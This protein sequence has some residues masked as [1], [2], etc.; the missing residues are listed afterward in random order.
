MFRIVLPLLALLTSISLISPAAAQ[1]IKLATLA[2]KGSPWHEVM[3]DLGEEW[4]EASG[5]KVTLRIYPGGVI[6]DEPDMVRK[7]RIGQLH[8]AALTGAGLSGIAPEIQALQMPM[9]F[10]SDRELSCTRGTIGPKLEAI[11]E[12]KGFKVLAWGNAGWVYFFAPGPVIEPKDM[13][14][15]S[16]FVWTG[17]TAVVEAYK[18][19]GFKPVPLAATEILAALQSGLVQSFPTTPVAALSFQWFGLAKH[20]ADIKWAPLIGA[21]V[22]STKKWQS[23][24]D[25]L[26]P[27]L[28]EMARAAGERLRREMPKLEAQAIEAMKSHGL[29]VHPVPSDKIASWEQVAQAGLTGII[30]TVV[31]SDLVTQV[32]KA[33]D[34]CRT[35]F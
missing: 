34:R 7:I 25:E 24:P 35:T 5:G 10:R 21:I 19:M 3:R 2:P 22:V 4:K 31:P 32:E 20:M 33:R 23:V 8:G 18:K 9:M 15:Y 26:K 12:K 14:P 27:R 29:M 28:E 13:K 17:E 30:G 16:I 11:L 1:E 6:G